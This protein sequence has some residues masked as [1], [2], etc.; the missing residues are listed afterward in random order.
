MTDNIPAGD[1]LFRL[2]LRVQTAQT[3]G[4]TLTMRPEEVQALI[5]VVEAGEGIQEGCNCHRCVALA[6]LRQVL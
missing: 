6:R 2:K 4:A 5:D 1:P 3:A